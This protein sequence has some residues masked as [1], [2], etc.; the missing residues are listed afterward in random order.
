MK[1]AK[2][3]KKL[4][5]ICKNPIPNSLLDLPHEKDIVIRGRKICNLPY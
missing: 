1:L 5:C 3:Q 2:Q 4:S